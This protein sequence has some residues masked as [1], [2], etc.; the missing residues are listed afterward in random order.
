M[1]DAE[2]ASEKELMMVT[3][4]EQ[5]KVD[6]SYKGPHI[7]LPMNKGHLEAMLAHFRANKVTDRRAQHE[8]FPF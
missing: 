6:K 2:Q 4:P 3:D 8:R 1:V 7:S 5:F